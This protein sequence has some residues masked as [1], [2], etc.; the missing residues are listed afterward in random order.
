[1]YGEH[2]GAWVDESTVPNN[3][4]AKGQARLDAEIQWTKYATQRNVPL[5]LL[6]LAGIYGPN[7]NALRTFLKKPAVVSQ[8]ASTSHMLVSR[9][10]LEDIVKVVYSAAS[11]SDASNSSPVVFNV[12]DDEP[13]SRADVFAF[14]AKLLEPHLSFSVSV[15]SGA[16]SDDN[17][18]SARHQQ[19]ASKRVSNA[20]MKRLLLPNLQYPSYRHGLTAMLSQ[21]IEQQ[22]SS[23]PISAKHH[24]LT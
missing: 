9:V 4:A 19:R 13:A 16:L 24:S 18:V 21:V 12:A 17:L 14:C 15:N 6:R 23:P 8:T 22:L 11:T 10:H 5:Y 7:R 1:M 2:E 3:P 20:K